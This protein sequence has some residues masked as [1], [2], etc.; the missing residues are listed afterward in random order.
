MARVESKE[1]AE[2]LNHWQLFLE[3]LCE[4]VSDKIG[5]K[6]KVLRQLRSIVTIRYG[7]VLNPNILLSFIQPKPSKQD[8]ETENW[9]LDLNKSQKRAV[10]TILSDNDLTLIQGPPGTGKTQVIAEACL[11]LFRNNPSIKILVCSE[12]HIAVNNILERVSELNSEMK[13]LRIQDKEES[14]SMQNYTVE[15]VLKNYSLWIEDNVRNPEVSKILME[16]FIESEDVK[17]VEKSLFLSA[18]LVGMTCNRVGAYSFNNSAEMFDVVIIDEVCKATLPEILMPLSVCK[19]AVL[20]GDPK[21][22]SPVFT[23]EERS[24]IE[25]IENSNLKEYMYIN[26]IFEEY[27]HSVLLDTQYR[28]SSQIGSLISD[29]FYSGMLIDGRNQDVIDAVNWIDYK[30]TDKWPLIEEMNIEFLG[31]YN[32]DEC[33]IIRQLIYSI[34]NEDRDKSIAVITPYRAQVDKL[35]MILKD[36]MLNIT[37][38]TVDG[39]QGKESDIVIFSLTRNHGSFRFLSDIRRLNVALSRAKDKIFIV[40]D[41][42]YSSKN[43]ILSEIIKRSKITEFEV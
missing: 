21:Q 30:A 33:N 6:T 20:V 3:E 19:K 11:Q 39:F 14:S 24:I 1:W 9:H 8:F 37:I 4:L 26:R 31:I 29:L 34:R 42:N 5:E 40:G 23:T 2:H 43:K 7:A 10:N 28:M 41:I 17:S 27:N 12:T 32:L 36:L 13:I 35:K 25:S 38:D 16:S 22:L 15:T 18:N